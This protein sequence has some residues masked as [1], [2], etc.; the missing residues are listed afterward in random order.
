MLKEILKVLMVGLFVAFFFFPSFLSA[1]EKEPIKI[2]LITTLSGTYSQPGAD[3]QNGV[4]FYL[5]KIGYKMADR[6][7]EL[8]A[9]DEEASG[10][11]A[12]TKARKL[13]ELNRVHALIGPIL[14]NGAYAVQPYQESK[15]VPNLYVAAAEDLTQR[16]RGNWGIRTGFGS[17]S[18]PMHPFAEYAY[19]VLGLRKVAVVACDYAFGW[20]VVGGFHKSFEDMGG[21]IV[22]KIWFPITT[23]DFS[24]YLTQ[25]RRDADAMFSQMGG[26]AAVVLNKQFQQYGLKDKMAS[27]GLM[28]ITDESI[29]PTMGD[30]AVG[31]ITAGNYSGVLD[32]RFNKEFVRG[33]QKRFGKIPSL[34][35]VIHYD[36]IAAI[37]QAVTSL[38]GDVSNPEKLMKALRS[39]NLQESPRGPIKLDAYGNVIQNIYIRKTE[40]VGGELQ[41]TVIY[42]YPEVSQFW[43]YEPEEFLKQPVYSRD[44]PPLKP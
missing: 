24:P 22:Q 2:G 1:Q 35:S 32:N 19:K 34:F 15:K 43:K 29:L 9:E 7:V 44:Y 18:Q 12:L 36:S 25:L 20:E 5:E 30:E 31:I 10:S 3:S 14:A 40:R 23:S 17:S 38:K 8:I 13:V 39:V 42:T 4:I 37:H 21:K 26:K 11:V 28:Q 16:K 41:N 6:K 33:Y 27:I